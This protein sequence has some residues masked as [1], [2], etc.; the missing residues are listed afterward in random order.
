MLTGRNHRDSSKSEILKRGREKGRAKKKESENEK[1]VA[2]V[3]YTASLRVNYTRSFTLS[4]FGELN[5]STVVIFLC[6]MNAFTIYCKDCK[7]VRP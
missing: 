3:H 6:G 4:L 5:L 7:T 1:H 2:L